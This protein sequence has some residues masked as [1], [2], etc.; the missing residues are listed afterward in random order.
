MTVPNMKA[1]TEGEVICSNETIVGNISLYDYHLK[2]V[3]M[4]K[5]GISE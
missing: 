2:F 4:P 5:N 3:S 1:K